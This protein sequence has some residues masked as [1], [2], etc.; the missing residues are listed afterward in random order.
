MVLDL[1]GARDLVIV[2][3][4]S[5]FAIFLLVL[6]VV[7]IVVGLAA[8]GLISV[9]KESIQTDVKQ[10]LAKVNET[11][12]NVKGAA[13]FMTDTT[14]APVIRMYSTVSATKQFVKT[15]SGRGR[16]KRRFPIPFRSR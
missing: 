12:T 15:I 9:V 3:W 14:V 5:L 16:K 11:A 13:E 4:G 2:I 7:T 6:I 10:T 1:A 8:R